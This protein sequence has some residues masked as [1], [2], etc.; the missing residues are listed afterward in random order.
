MIAVAVGLALVAAV[1][2]V[3][4]AVIALVA[5]VVPTVVMVRAAPVVA[6]IVA[7]Q[8]GSGDGEGQDGTGD[9]LEK[10]MKSPLCGT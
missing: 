1:V 6:A 7:R 9:A 8:H 4:P 10:F 2:P 3:I 5:A